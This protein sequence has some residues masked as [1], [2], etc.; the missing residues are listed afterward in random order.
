[1]RPKGDPL[2]SS[3]QYEWARWVNLEYFW[4]FHCVRYRGQNHI[5]EQ[6]PIIFAPNHV[7]YYD[8]P[9][10]GAGIPFPVR[11]MAWDALFTVPVLKQ[12]LEKFGAY[13]V[14]PNSADKGSIERTLKILRHGEAVMIFPEGGRSKDGKLMPFEMGVARMAIQTGAKIIPVSVTNVYE[15]W[16]CHRTWPK[17]F[18]PFTIKFH[19]PVV[20]P[21]NVPRPELKT[22]IERM[23]EEIAAPIRRRL[24]AWERYK[25]RHSK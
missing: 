22:T 11:F 12:I 15:S 14:K 21:E 6:G 18:V 16:S 4:L 5:P 2:R 10:V 19:P 3:L 17:L 7:S 23:N 20:P 24:A 13:P 9:L 25:A 1:M 8:P